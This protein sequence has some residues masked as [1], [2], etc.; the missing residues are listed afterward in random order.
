M[1]A[2]KF[3]LLKQYQENSTRC[4]NRHV[5][6]SGGCADRLQFKGLTQSPMP[7][8]PRRAIKPAIGRNCPTNWFKNTYLAKKTSQTPCQFSMSATWT[9]SQTALSTRNT[10]P[11]HEKAQ[12][13]ANLDAT[14]KAAHFCGEKEQRTHI[15]CT[16]Q[17]LLHV[18]GVRTARKATSTTLR[19]ASAGGGLTRRLGPAP[20]ART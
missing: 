2:I 13:H 9:K 16:L 17:P 4:H 8:T 12:D 10:A 3:R 19:T 7:T 5:W 18:K 6:R 11:K 1:S 20:G 14:A 15:A